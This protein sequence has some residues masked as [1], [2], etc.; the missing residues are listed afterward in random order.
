M[1]ILACWARAQKCRRCFYVRVRID[2]IPDFIVEPYIVYTVA[3][4]FLNIFAILRQIYIFYY[5]SE[6]Q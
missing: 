1:R 4:N 3:N 2:I 5:F 6:F